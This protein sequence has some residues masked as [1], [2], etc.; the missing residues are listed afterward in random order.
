VIPAEQ[1]PP[2]PHGPD[3]LT[4]Q[5][6]AAIR[7]AVL[8]L[9]PLTEEQIKEICEVIVNFRQRHPTHPHTD[10]QPTR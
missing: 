10:K 1:P 9:P 5:D 2:R 3:E 6:R 4:D 8:A 7:A